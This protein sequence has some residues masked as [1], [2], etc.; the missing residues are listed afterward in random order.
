MFHGRYEARRSRHASRPRGAHDARRGRPAVVSR[1]CLRERRPGDRCASDGSRKAHGQGASEDR[2]HRQ[3]H[4][5]QD[6]RAARDGQSHEAR[7]LAAKTSVERR[8]AASDPRARTEGRCQAAGGAGGS[9][10]RRPPKGPG[11]AQASRAQGFR[12]EVRG[13]AR[14]IARAARRARVGRPHADFG[15][16]SARDAHRGAD[17]RPSGRD[18][19]VVLRVAA[20][21]LGDDRR[22]RH[23]R[24]GERAGANHGGARVDELRGP[25]PRARGREDERRHAPRHAGRR[26]RRRRSPARRRAALFHRLGCA[27]AR[28][29]EGGRSTSTRSPKSRGAKSLRARRRSRSTRRSGCRSFRPCCARTRARS[30]R[31]KAGRSLAPSGR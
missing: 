21:F 8:C 28:S 1:A 15:R 9:V 30:K 16:A 25:R 18:A 4:R 17:A 20:T 14:A 12:C 27:S 23:H 26:T 10:H 22:H 31:R 24:G 6:P 5:R 2:G 11:R 29:R 3:K 19:R 13:E 7:G